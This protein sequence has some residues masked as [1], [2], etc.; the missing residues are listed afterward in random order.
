M[1]AELSILHAAPIN[2]FND[3]N[4]PQQ[5]AGKALSLGGHTTAEAYSTS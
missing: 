2:Y 1:Q 3:D 4:P 5:L